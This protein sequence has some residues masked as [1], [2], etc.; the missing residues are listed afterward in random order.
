MTELR[1][2][3]AP[4]RSTT[5]AVIDCVLRSRPRKRSAAIVPVAYRC[6]N[7]APYEI[8]ARNDLPELA[9]PGDRQRTWLQHT[10]HTTCVVASGLDL[11]VTGRESDRKVIL[12]EG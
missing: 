2:T 4:V 1:A 6:T 8:L 7:S 5:T 12:P 3:T 10:A 9:G 11:E